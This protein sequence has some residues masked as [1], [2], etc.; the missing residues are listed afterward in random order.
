M[1]CD[2]CSRIVIKFFFKQVLSELTIYNETMIL[3]NSDSDTQKTVL[4]SE[5]S[6]CICSVPILNN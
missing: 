6:T 5:S 4:L 1:K 3:N 2:H